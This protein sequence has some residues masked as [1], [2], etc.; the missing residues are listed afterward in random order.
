MNK[1]GV[2]LG[3]KWLSKTRDLRVSGHVI[4]L[5][6]GPARL[7]RQQGPPIALRMHIASLKQSVS[8]QIAQLGPDEAQEGWWIEMYLHILHY[9][10][11]DKRSETCHSLAPVSCPRVVPN[12]ESRGSVAQSH[13]KLRWVRSGSCQ[14]KA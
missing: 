8:G 2:D 14:E 6:E 4:I 10:N 1:G 5:P 13:E 3:K 9:C 11:G 12:P 7:L